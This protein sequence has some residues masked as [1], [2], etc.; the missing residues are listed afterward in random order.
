MYI[1]KKLGTRNFWAGL[2]VIYVVGDVIELGSAPFAEPA[3][4]HAPPSARRLFLDLRAEHSHTG[5]GAVSHTLV[6]I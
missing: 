5:H 3:G 6:K 2:C 1:N 4:G